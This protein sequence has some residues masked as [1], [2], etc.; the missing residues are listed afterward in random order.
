MPTR[1]SAQMLPTRSP[2]CWNS[3]SIALESP[4]RALECPPASSRRRSRPGQ[5]ITSSS[6]MRRT[7]AA[8]ACQRR[9]TRQCDGAARPGSVGAS[10]PSVAARDPLPMIDQRGS[11]T[12]YPEEYGRPDGRAMQAL[13][14]PVLEGIRAVVEPLPEA[15][16]VADDSGAIRLTND[17]ADRMFRARPVRSTDDLLSRFED[18]DIQPAQRQDSGPAQLRVRPRNQ[19]NTW[20]VLD[21]TTLGTDRDAASIFILRD[22]TGTAELRPEREAFLG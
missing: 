17:A 7:P 16:L 20:F 10:L 19:P 2:N 21:R 14:A 15:V 12:G 22:V 13:A 9:C 18:A 8:T 4:R 11:D 1:G 3:A 6:P 5:P